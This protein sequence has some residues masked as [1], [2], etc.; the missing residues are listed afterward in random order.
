MCG[1]LLDALE[2]KFEI[3]SVGCQSH[4]FVEQHPAIDCSWSFIRLY[5]KLFCQPQS[6]LRS[7]G[8][9][10]FIVKNFLDV[11]KRFANCSGG[12]GRNEL[13]WCC[14]PTRILWECRLVDARFEADLADRIIAV[15]SI[16]VL[17]RDRN[18]PPD[19][20]RHAIDNRIGRRIRERTRIRADL[21]PGPHSPARA[22][23]CVHSQK[24][25][26][27]DMSRTAQRGVGGEY[28]IVANRG[29]VAERC[30]VVEQRTP[31]GAGRVAHDRIGAQDRANANHCGSRNNRSGM[32]ER[33]KLSAAGGQRLG[34][35]ATGFRN[36]DGQHQS[37][38]RLGLVVGWIAQHR[39]LRSPLLETVGVGGEKSCDTTSLRGPRIKGPLH[40]LPPKASG[41]DDE[42]SLCF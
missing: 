32:N 37:I 38:A 3:P 20:P 17:Q 28:R 4:H 1:A 9:R 5:E 30:V 15:A 6:P 21:T 2:R 12:G 40:N 31:A 14:E 27:A 10:K 41:P 19:P 8:G 23:R 26:V 29:I 25:I 18:P 7:G 11:G 24:D 33:E 16:K 39:E 22:D 34:H 36:A 42:N 13:R 35:T